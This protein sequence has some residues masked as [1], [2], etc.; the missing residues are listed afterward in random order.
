MPALGYEDLLS[1][2]G[3]SVLP[4]NSRC[5]LVGAGVKRCLAAQPVAP[6]GL[7]PDR[8]R[9]GALRFFEAVIG[10]ASDG[11]AFWPCRRIVGE[12]C[13]SRVSEVRA[14]RNRRPA[15]VDAA[16]HDCGYR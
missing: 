6:R 1:F 2:P 4:E 12:G 14:R 3:I 13:G 15:Q 8:A 10:H 9:L 7:V 5:L 16:M 11:E